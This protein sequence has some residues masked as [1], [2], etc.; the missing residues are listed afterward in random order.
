MA[1]VDYKCLESL[2]IEGADLIANEKLA[3]IEDTA[4][5][6]SYFGKKWNCNVYLNVPEERVDEAKAALNKF[7]SA[8]SSLSSKYESW[9]IN[10]IK[11]N[12]YFEFAVE[13]NVVPKN[14]S[15]YIDIPDLRLNDIE[16]STTYRTKK[17]VVI[18]SGGYA[19]DEE[20]GWAIA[21]VNNKVI[22]NLS[23]S[24][25]IHNEYANESAMMDDKIYQKI[26]NVIEPILPSGVSETVIHLSYNETKKAMSVEIKITVD[27]KTS[28]LYTYLLKNGDNK[29]ARLLFMSIQVQITG[30]AVQEWRKLDNDN[31]WSTMTLTVDPS[32]HFTCNFRY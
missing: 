22:G 8:S 32:G 12:P 26:Y 17:M 4:K 11:N 9:M 21:F 23:E 14:I 25:S 2:L 20:H 28:D 15:K 3:F 27:G 16:V 19:I 5:N 10:Q 24:G 6:V 29:K 18:I 7:L 13:D 1:F 30:M 31:K